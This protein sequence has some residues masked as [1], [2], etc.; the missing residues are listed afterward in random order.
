MSDSQEPAR[1]AREKKTVGL[2][3]A[4]WCRAK[5]DTRGK[6]CEE[7]EALRRYAFQRLD[8]CPFG[9]KKTTCAQCPI[10]CYKPDMREKIRQVMR[11]AGPRML[12][13]HPVLALWHLWDE[14]RSKR[15]ERAGQLAAGRT[16]KKLVEHSPG[17]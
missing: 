5:H 16:V 8:R 13:H 2:M 11:F 1:I 17:S 4:L 12:W 10:H 15:A 3:I 7:C 9:P 14:W 6:L